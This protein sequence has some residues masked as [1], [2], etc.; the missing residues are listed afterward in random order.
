MLH[1]GRIE[2]YKRP[3]LA[4]SVAKEMGLKPLIIGRGSYRDK[5][6][7]TMDKGL[8][9]PATT[10]LLVPAGE[11]VGR[12]RGALEGALSITLKRHYPAKF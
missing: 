10:L 3:D 1:A 11:E 12:G 9:L 2:K 4:V 6:T 7:T 8:I 5:H